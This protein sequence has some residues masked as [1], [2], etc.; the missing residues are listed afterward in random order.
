MKNITEQIEETTSKKTTEQ[1]INGAIEKLKNGDDGAHWEPNCIEAARQLLNL[2]RAMFQRKRGEIK[3]ASKDAQITE[4]TKNVKQ[5]SDT[6]SRGED[7]SKA[8]ELV[9]LVKDSSELFHS[10]K[11]ECYS[12]FEQN[13]HKETWPLGSKGF[14]DWLG[15]KAYAELEFSLSDAVAKQVITTLKG[16]AKYEGKQREVYLRCAPCE[17]GY[18]VD[19]TNEHWQAVKVTANGWHIIDSPEVK[20]IRS[21]TSTELPIPENTGDLNKLWKHTNIPTSK[22]LLV[23][24]CLLET[25]RPDTPY[26]V[27]V[28]TG[29]Q[30]SAKSSTHKR[31]RQITDPNSVPLR[32]APNK[33]EDVFVS[34]ANNHQASF[35]NMSNL[36]SSMQDALCTI[37]TG[38]GFAARKLYSDSDESVIEVKR[39]VIINGIENPVTRPDLIDRSIVLTLPKIE[40]VERKR[41]AVLEKEY[42]KDVPAIFTGLLNLFSATLKELPGINIDRPPR[43]IDFSYLGEAMCKAIGNN[44]SF[45]DLYKENR[46]ESLMHSMDSSPAILAVMEFLPKT[47]RREFKGTLKELKEILDK[48]HRQDGEG[49]PNSPKGLGNILRRMTAALNS[50][51]IE[52]E[53][54]KRE[55]IGYPVHIFFQ[56]K[57]ECEN[58]VHEAHQVHQNSGSGQNLINNEQSGERSVLSERNHTK[59]I[60]TEK[61]YTAHEHIFSDSKRI[62]EPSV[63]PNDSPPDNWEEF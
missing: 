17:D 50:A 63:P 49:W 53:F 51:G 19:L 55:N 31:L 15:F 14:G 20:F 59:E 11:G 24:A 30:G 7:D 22:K 16:I 40:E 33:K 3:K 58:N 62:F 54:L 27:M 10:E 8:S 23:L 6:E 57:K 9:N 36:S 61:T 47:D 35:E 28:I 46:T 42:L 25:F 56:H 39:P 1:V 18:I 32:V 5:E 12:T 41:D 29:G 26:V 52:V 34:A 44:I 2:D 48:S 43:M 13:K 37:A 60:N 4:W 38:G 45:N 21:S